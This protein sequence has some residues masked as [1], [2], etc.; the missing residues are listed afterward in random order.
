MDMFEAKTHCED[1]FEHLQTLPTQVDAQYQLQ[2]EY[3]CFR[4]LCQVNLPIY[5]W[6]QLPH[7]GPQTRQQT[8]TVNIF[9][10]KR[11]EKIENYVIFFCEE[12]YGPVC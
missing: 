5:F 8:K 7:Y 4:T 10:Q 1:M 11:N 3:Q 6:L 9:Y 2:R 12:Y